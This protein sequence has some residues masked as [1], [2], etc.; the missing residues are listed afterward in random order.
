MW[1][2]LLAV[3]AVA[4]L[5]A[6]ALFLPERLLVWGDGQ[7]LDRLHMDAQDQA[8]EG[9]GE[10]LQLTVPE[11][12]LLLRS[13]QLT[14]MNLN[15]EIL[16]YAGEGGF[17]TEEEQEDALSEELSRYLH[18]SEQLWAARVE[19]LRGEIASLQTLGGLPEVWRAGSPPDYTAQGEILYLDEDS[20]M[21]FQVYQIALYWEKYSMELLVDSQ[22]GRILSFLLHWSQGSRPSWGFRGGAGFGG[23]W[24]DYWGMDSVSTGW[25]G[26]RVR[27]MLENMEVQL[28]PSGEVSG[29]DQ[30]TFMYG[31]QPVPIPLACQGA[32]SWS[33]SL[34]WNR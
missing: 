30:I 23:A 2:K 34:A 33:F 24:R 32:L 29:Y 8:R 17:L 18:E 15:Q 16:L 5:V 28:P 21:N 31:G 19:A 26:Q 22:S 1:N 3:A 11:K 9:F 20:R 10:S 25:Y 14:A 4:L 13:G 6:G 27:D 12:L 7:L